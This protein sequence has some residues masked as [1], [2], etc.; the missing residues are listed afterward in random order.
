M[1]QTLNSLRVCGST[2]LA[3]VD[4][5]DRGVRRHQ[6]TVGILGEVLMPGR[7]QDID[8]VSVILKLHAQT[9]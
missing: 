6:R 1:A 3:A 4:D 2:P 7:I 9:R 8:A 5:H